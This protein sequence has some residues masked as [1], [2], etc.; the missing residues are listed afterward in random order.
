MS[1]VL[2]PSLLHGDEKRRVIDNNSLRQ[3]RSVFEANLF[4]LVGPLRLHNLAVGPVYG[5]SVQ[6]EDMQGGCG[7]LNGD[8]VSRRG[9]T[10]EVIPSP[11]WWHGKSAQIESGVQEA[12]QPLADRRGSVIGLNDLIEIVDTDERQLIHD[13]FDVP[14]GS[15]GPGKPKGTRH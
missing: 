11:E 5:V 12:V 4:T 6:F 9:S 3:G 8:G 7:E 10:V 13:K 15:P 1:R 2:C 14:N